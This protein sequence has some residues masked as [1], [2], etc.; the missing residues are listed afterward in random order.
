VY[1][2][3]CGVRISEGAAF[4][5][6]CGHP[7][8]T[9]SDEGWYRAEQQLSPPPARSAAVAAPLV[10]E[11]A[12]HCGACG[13]PVNPGAFACPGCGAPVSAALGAKNKTTAVLL[14]C[15]LGPWTWVYTYKLESKKFW[16][17]VV[18]PGVAFLLAIIASTAF[19]STVTDCQYP[20]NGCTPLSSGATASGVFAGIFFIVGLLAAIGI[21]IWSIVDSASKNDWYYARFPNG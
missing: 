9:R 18:V 3:E 16:I 7:L 12:R 10:S 1:C 14:A 13:R 19:T 21:H 5:D 6:S 15:F 11:P 20:Y 17:G 8:S 4:C 2:D